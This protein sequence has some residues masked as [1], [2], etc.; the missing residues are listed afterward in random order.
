[1]ALNDLTH[2]ASARAPLHIHH[3]QAGRSKEASCLRR[4]ET[5]AMSGIEN[6]ELLGQGLNTGQ[7]AVVVWI[8][9][10]VIEK[11]EVPLRGTIKHEQDI[12]R[13][14]LDL[15]LQVEEARLWL[16]ANRIESA[17]AGRCPARL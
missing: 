12:Q 11:L 13:A 15:T 8:G 16:A 14:M 7:T 10:G 5:K 9:I 6:G 2:R 4:R 17:A 1:Q 3:R